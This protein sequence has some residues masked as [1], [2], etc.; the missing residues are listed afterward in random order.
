MSLKIGKSTRDIVGKVDL[1]QETVNTA[2]ET[3]SKRLESN[4]GDYKENLKIFFQNNND[5]KDYFPKDH[6]F[7]DFDFLD[8]SRGIVYSM[9]F[10]EGAKC[11]NRL[12]DIPIGIGK[13][14]KSLFTKSF[15]S[16]S[17]YMFIQSQAKL[18][19]VELAK[20]RFDSLAITNLK[21]FLYDEYAKTSDITVLNED[22]SPDVEKLKDFIIGSFS[23]LS[24]LDF[25]YEIDGHVL[26]LFISAEDEQKCQMETVNINY[27]VYGE[28]MR[29]FMATLVH[30]SGNQSVEE[31]FKK[32]MIENV[33]RELLKCVTPPLM[34][35]V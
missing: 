4:Q 14:E 8:H 11:V 23:Q 13:V 24:F 16:L 27:D 15:Y 20:S 35:Q 19:P 3:A 5:F 2:S 30:S 29:T 9:T 17:T 6:A 33:C 28:G 32:I 22:Y 34:I 21:L 18:I 31:E 7:L 1:S 12:K 26:K 25:V 10:K